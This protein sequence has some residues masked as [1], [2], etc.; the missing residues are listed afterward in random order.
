MIKNQVRA[1]SKGI[2][3]GTSAM[4]QRGCGATILKIARDSLGSQT[5]C[6]GIHS[7]Y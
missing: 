6:Q 2:A 1:F 3:D 7:I 4:P 5:F